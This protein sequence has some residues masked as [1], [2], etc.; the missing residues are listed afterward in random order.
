MPHDYRCKTCGRHQVF[1]HDTGKAPEQCVTK[2]CPGPVTVDQ[3][4]FRCKK[5]GKNMAA[6]VAGECQ[7]PNACTNC[8]AGITLGFDPLKSHTTIVDMI[9]HE[10][11][12]VKRPL[13][14]EEVVALGKRIQEK[15]DE[16]PTARILYPENW[17][18]LAKC[19]DEELA[20][21]E[22]TRE[23]VATHVPVVP[24]GPTGKPKNVFTGAQEQTGAVDHTVA[25]V[26]HTVA[27]KS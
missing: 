20:G 24:T 21:Y 22:L 16:L 4:A 23:Q 18:I 26:E 17:I 27:E 7:V 12:R 11:N 1:N 3:F 6:A 25:E 15:L 10:Q 19:T 2:D 5:C 14:K 8:K 9:D 13:T